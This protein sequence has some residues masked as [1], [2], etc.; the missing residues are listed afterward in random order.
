MTRNALIV[1][2][3]GFIGSL[4][5]KS[6]LDNAEYANVV[7]WVRKKL[8]IENSKLIQEEINFDNIKDLEPS[9]PIDDVFCALGTMMRKAGSKEAFCT[10]DYTYVCDTAQWAADHQV[11]H[12]LVVSLMG[13]N[14]KSKAFYMKTK[15]E[16]ENFVQN[17]SIPIIGFFRPSLLFGRTTE[18]RFGELIESFFMRL[19]TPFLSKKYRGIPGAAGLLDDCLANRENSGVHIIESDQMQKLFKNRPK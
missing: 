2:A 5:L 19:A 12:L 17:C 9:I 1:G 14:S 6:L 13:A 3:S 15:G 8:P 11:Q 7:I 16:M 10:V 18:F 4:I